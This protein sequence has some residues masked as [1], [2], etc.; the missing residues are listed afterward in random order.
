MTYNFNWSHF[1]CVHDIEIL[2]YYT[3]KDNLTI[4]YTKNLTVGEH[5]EVG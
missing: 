4:S 5:Q 2:L 3:H 1:P